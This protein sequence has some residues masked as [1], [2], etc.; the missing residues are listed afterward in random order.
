MPPRVAIFGAGITGLTA[1][2]ELI[3]RGFR[4]RVYEPTRPGPDDEVCGVG[5]MARTQWARVRVPPEEYGPPDSSPPDDDAEFVAAQPLT[6]DRAE[7][8]GLRIKFAS[9]KSVLDAATKTM[10]RD[11]VLP[12]AKEIDPVAIVVRGYCSDPQLSVRVKPE[13]TDFDYARAQAVAN[14]LHECGID[15]SRLTPAAFGYG[16]PDDP[17]A[18]ANDRE[19]VAF[20]LVEELLPG[21]HG[22]RFFPSFYRHLFN[23]MSRIPLAA[24]G[25][26]FRESGRTVLDNLVTPETQ[27]VNYDSGMYEMPRRMPQSV[28]E[29]VT[30][31]RESL[32][33]SG[34]TIEDAVRLQEKFLRYLTACAK[35]RADY[36]GQ[37]WWDFVE[38]PRYSARCQ[39]YLETSPQMLVAMRATE[40]DARTIGNV[41]AQL[42][43]DQFTNGERTDRTLNGPTTTAWLTP[44]RRYLVRQGVDFVRGELAELRDVAGRTIAIVRTPEDPSEKKPRNKQWSPK[45]LDFDYYVVAVPVEEAKKLVK[46]SKFDSSKCDCGKIARLDLGKPDQ[47][48]PG[49]MVDHLSGIQF[50]FRSEVA[51]VRGHTVYPDSE[52]G[53]S[54]IAQP[55]FWTTR[56]GWWDGYRGVLSV[57]I[58]NWHAK[59]RA[60]EGDEEETGAEKKTAWQCTPDVIA[61][62]VWRQITRTLIAEPE[63]PLYYHLDENIEIGK[64]GKPARNK[65]PMLINRTGKFGERPGEFDGARFIYHLHNKQL[66]FAGTYL[67]TFTRLTCMETANESARHA[68][69]AILRDAK[70]QGDEPRIWNPEHHEFPDLQWLVQIDERLHAAKLPHVFDVL[71]P[72]TA[73]LGLGLR[74]AGI[75]ITPGKET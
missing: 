22:F 20:Q 62:E 32:E 2:H 13:E 35:R 38:G 1:A 52:W 3:E 71:G 45:A 16:L 11:Q 7:F 40:C 49:G 72:S 4:V 70:F 33:R 28:T 75:T 8:L 69:S 30:A 23:T 29:L 59:A 46:S 65:S 63:R 37:S 17:R 36:E 51:F 14:F 57:D 44:W 9:G 68:V 73:R 61:Q 66:V 48:T 6:S 39:R 42:Y 15:E 27:G 19:Y 34:V 58:G 18:A 56:R 53:L 67:Q 10:L 5:G 43:V 50:Y 47:E 74:R 41:A 12:F 60:R 64:N 25:P 24:P 21:E 54:S 55:Q 26:V 31:L